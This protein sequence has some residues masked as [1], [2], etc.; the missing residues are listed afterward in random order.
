MALVRSRAARLLIAPV[1]GLAALVAGSAVGAGSA[2]ASSSPFTIVIDTGTTGPYGANGTA[3]VQGVEAAANVLNKT[4]GGILGHK[5]KVTVLDN[6]GNP[7]TAATLLEQNLSSGKKP[8]MIEPGSIS[9]EG[10]VEVPIANAA[11]VLSIGTPNASSLND[12]KKYPDEFLMAPDAILSEESLMNYAKAHHY[13]KIAMIYSSDAYGASVGQATIAAAKAAGITLDTATYEDTDLSVTS[14]LQQLQADKPQMLY[15][16]G[17]GSP[18]G[19]ILQDLYTLGWKIPT[20]GDLTTAATPLI[21][22]D[23]NQPQEK[24]VLIQN[25][26]VAEYS[27]NESTAVKNYIHAMES[28]GPITTPLNTTSYQYD[29]VMVVAQAAKQA[30]SITTPA[31]VKALEHL[32][33]PSNPLWVTLDKYVFSPSSHAPAASPSNWIVTPVS[34]LTNGQY[35]GPAS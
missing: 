31:L 8:D 27:P 16:Q 26:K 18:C 15:T 33:Q 35:G 34:A 19:V 25:L 24:G 20:I 10:V 23:A 28:F 13:S 29:S 6:D 11:K 4:Q 1:V 30:K 14:Q 12:P 5:V 21:A 9:T 3:A 7:T 17:F 22:T 2:G 32:K